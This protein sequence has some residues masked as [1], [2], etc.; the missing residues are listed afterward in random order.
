[1]QPIEHRKQHY[2]ISGIEIDIILDTQDRS[3]RRKLSMRTPQK[4]A[5]VIVRTTETHRMEKRMQTGIHNS[6]ED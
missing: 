5:M 3:D 2:D 6:E 1:M 4:D